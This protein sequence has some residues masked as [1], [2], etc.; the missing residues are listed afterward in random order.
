[1]EVLCFYLAM[2]LLPFA[3]V[4]VSQLILLW[5]THLN[6]QNSISSFPSFLIHSKS[7]AVPLIIGL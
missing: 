6:N 7:K 1:M 4:M 5:Q 3:L 2:K